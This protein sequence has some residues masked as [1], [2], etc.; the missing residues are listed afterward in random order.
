MP[1]QRLPVPAGLDSS[2]RDRWAALQDMIAANAALE[3]EI[4]Q[5][6][7]SLSPVSVLF[8]RLQG[9]IDVLYPMEAGLDAQ[10]ARL[11][12]D[13]FVQRSAAESLAQGKSEVIKTMLA[14]GAQIP[15]PLLDKMAAQ[16]GLGPKGKGLYRGA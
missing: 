7:V 5:Y 3:A 1:Y 15:K 13:E 16:Q 2:L 10:D 8:A 6:G 14:Q 9:L 4:G 11:R 12:I